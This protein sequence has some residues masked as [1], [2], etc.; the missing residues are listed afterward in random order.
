ML[1][2]LSGTSTTR[3]TSVRSTVLVILVAALALGVVG[4]AGLLFGAIPGVG[5]AASASPSQSP[6]DSLDPAPTLACPAGQSL[7]N[8]GLTAAGTDQETPLAAAEEWQNTLPNHDE[9]VE[10][11]QF[12]GPAGSVLGARTVGW[13]DHDGTLRA[14]AVVVPAA[15]GR[16]QLSRTASCV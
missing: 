14:T 13:Y 8:G 3:S 12:A 1:D 5:S 2:G 9:M 4:G 15:A 6:V 7:S 10:A 16:W 11:R